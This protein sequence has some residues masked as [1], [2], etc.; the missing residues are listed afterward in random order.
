[1]IIFNHPGHKDIEKPDMVC[2]R[3]SMVFK[4][5]GTA[6]FMLAPATGKFWYFFCYFAQNL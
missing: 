5:A 6:V 3:L 2:N 1:M 4:Q